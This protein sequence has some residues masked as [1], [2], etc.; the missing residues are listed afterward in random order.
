MYI[1][2]FEIPDFL[3]GSEFGRNLL[4]GSKVYRVG[5]EEWIEYMRDELDVKY[6]AETDE[7]NTLD[8]FINLI[9]V[10]EFWGLDY[11]ISI[12]IF[13]TINKETVTYLEDKYIELYGFTIDKFV[14]H[15]NWL[16]RNDQPYNDI[17]KILKK[18][19][20]NSDEKDKPYKIIKEFML[21]YELKDY[22]SK[23][24]TLTNDK[25][26]ILKL[27]EKITYFSE[28]YKSVTKIDG[29]DD[30][31]LMPLISLNKNTEIGGPAYGNLYKF[32]L[33]YHDPDRNYFMEDFYIYKPIILYLRINSIDITTFVIK[34]IYH[35]IAIINCI[36]R[37]IEFN[38]SVNDYVD[39]NY[40]N[41]IL[42]LY[43]GNM[44]TFIFHKYCFQ[45]N[46]IIIQ[47]EELRDTYIKDVE[48]KGYTLDKTMIDILII[49]NSK[50]TTLT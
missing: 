13:Y 21:D 19:L 46:F 23:I 36:K 1:T 50:I 11:C 48:N 4:E 44:V 35:L 9:D 29:I 20:N 2:L 40:N 37:Q 14:E 25:I 26:K 27:Y 33:S 15:L 38:I 8:E 12:F 17:N 42:S 47:L 24:I 18:I 28:V 49:K 6:F 3:K 39:M 7:V 34:N 16:N 41:E 43:D 30:F 22:N 5:S 32:S 10:C 31:Y 45:K